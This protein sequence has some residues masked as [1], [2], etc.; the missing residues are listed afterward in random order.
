M[1]AP[2]SNA[3]KRALNIAGGGFIELSNAPADFG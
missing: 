1:L 3:A 2:N